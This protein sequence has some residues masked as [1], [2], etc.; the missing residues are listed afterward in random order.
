MGRSSQMGGSILKITVFVLGLTA[1]GSCAKLDVVVEWRY[2]EFDYP[3]PA[4][5]AL[6]IQDGTYNFERA[7]PIDS[8]VTPEGKMFLTIRR[9]TGVPASLTVVNPDKL[10]KGGGPLLKPY[11]DWA[12]ANTEDCENIIGTYRMDLDQCNRLWVIDSGNVGD[13]NV[14]PPKILA[15]NVTSDKSIAKIVIPENVAK[16]ENGKTQFE[17]IVVQNEDADCA[18][19]TI[20]LADSAGNGIVIHDGKDFWRVSSSA[21]E[22]DPSA[23][24]F[25]VAGDKTVINSHGVLGMAVT[26]EPSPFD[27]HMYFR[28][29]SSYYMYDTKLEDLKNYKKDSSEL[30]VKKLPAKLP[31]Q[32]I[33]HSLAKQQILFFSSVKDSSIL[34]WN[35][36][37]EFTSSNIGLVEQ[38][39]VDLQW[40]SGVKVLSNNGTE[41]MKLW[42]LTN[43]WQDFQNQEIPPTIPHDPNYYEFVHSNFK[44]LTGEVSELIKGTVCE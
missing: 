28:P 10:G 23:T 17:N 32:S 42:V 26:E 8:I 9:Q 6:A 44:I 18:K 43:R 25:T 37:K 4:E 16:G 36:Q 3:T 30:P 13:E 11:P 2:L 21:F 38:N 33:T 22:P 15:F 7:I 5:E 19:T 29:L 20:Y 12:S 24:T 35:R 31:G 27:R 1:I 41:K 39:F 14:C 40:A 34:C